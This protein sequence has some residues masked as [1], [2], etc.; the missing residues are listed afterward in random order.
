MLAQI[1]AEIHAPVRVVMMMNA[2]DAR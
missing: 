1:V 2:D